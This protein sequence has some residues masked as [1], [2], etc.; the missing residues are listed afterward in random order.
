MHKKQGTEG[1]NTEDDEEGGEAKGEEEG[2]ETGREGFR[3]ESTA[4]NPQRYLSKIFKNIFDNIFININFSPNKQSI[5]TQSEKLNPIK[6]NNNPLRAGSAN[7]S[8]SVEEGEEEEGSTAGE[9]AL[10]GL[11][12]EVEFGILSEL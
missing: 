7:L 11:L 10:I 12:D 4:S 5:S 8:W 1:G 9:I 6:I 2:R 3:L